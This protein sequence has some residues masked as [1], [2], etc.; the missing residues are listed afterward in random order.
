MSYEFENEEDECLEC[1]DTGEHF[2]G[3]SMIYCTCPVGTKLKNKKEGGNSAGD[4]E[5]EKPAKE[6]NKPF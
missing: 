2:N 5:V 3:K 6:P 4:N 1:F